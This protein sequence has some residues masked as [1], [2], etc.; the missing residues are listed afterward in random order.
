MKELQNFKHHDNPEITVSLPGI[1]KIDW[2]SALHKESVD[3]AFEKMK[4]FKFDVL[5]IMDA[6]G[7]Y[8]R[9]FKSKE[10]GK[11]TIDNIEEHEIKPHDC[12]YYLTNIEDAVKAF[13][14]S[15]QN[16]FFLVNETEIIGLINIS[17]LNS[18]H[19]YLFMY[20]LIA[21]LELSLGK[22]INKSGIDDPELMRIFIEN[23]KSVKPLTRYRGEDKKALDHKFIEYAYL[24][25]MAWIIK[26]KKLFRKIKIKRDEFDSSIKIINKMRNIAAHPV[27][28]LIK[29]KNSI[30][31][32]N[33][34]ITKANLII[35]K[36]NNYLIEIKLGA[37]KNFLS[38][39]K[40]NN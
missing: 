6:D 15:E 27:N 4:R 30:V 20:N 33:L 32:L 2:T 19:V 18:K 38:A 25:D 9:Y 11:Y 12:I 3:Q 28:S 13:A 14:E 7:S 8:K 26:E 40:L 17:N 29:G 23:N 37:R 24:G 16:F 21:Q 5:P 31:E 35:E 1:L 10:W 22:L 39:E 34:A 36:I